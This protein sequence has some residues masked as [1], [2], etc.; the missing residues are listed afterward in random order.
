MWP[1]GILEI[2]NGLTAGKGEAITGSS[3]AALF[4]SATDLDAASYML[5]LEEIAYD[6]RCLQVYLGKM[7]NH[8]VRITQLKEQWNRKRQEGAKEAVHKWVDQH[9]PWILLFI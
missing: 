8:E 5:A 9:A 6:E 1:T 4:K 7:S 3:E 2:L